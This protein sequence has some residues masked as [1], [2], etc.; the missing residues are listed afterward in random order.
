MRA[1]A[2][3]LALSADLLGLATAHRGAVDFPLTVLG[4][5]S[6]TRPL[7]DD[8]AVLE[9]VLDRCIHG[10]ALLYRDVGDRDALHEVPEVLIPGEAPGMIL[11]IVRGEP[12]PR[13]RQ[14]VRH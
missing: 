12:F 7:L 4:E 1:P 9:E 2:S 5:Q 13:C 11:L 6:I 8:P 3:R 14:V 10:V